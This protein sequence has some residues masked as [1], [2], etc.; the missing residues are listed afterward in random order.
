MIFKNLK[1]RHYGRG[2]SSPQIT[3]MTGCPMSKCPAAFAVE[4]RP[5]QPNVRFGSFADL[6]SLTDDVR[7]AP[8]E[9]T[10]QQRLAGSEIPA[11]SQGAA[12]GHP[13]SASA[14][15]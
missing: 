13:Q 8:E 6:C 15:P 7:F 11:R 3:S 9:Q 14:P 10:S 4:A 1:D 5:S 12:P 2:R